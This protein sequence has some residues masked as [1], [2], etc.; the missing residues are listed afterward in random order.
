MSFQGSDG[1]SVGLG[2]AA[3]ASGA[4]FAHALQMNRSASASNAD[5]VAVMQGL[6]MSDMQGSTGAMEDRELQQQ[7]Q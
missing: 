5:L 7:Q 6:S 2:R 1:R 3:S 4:D